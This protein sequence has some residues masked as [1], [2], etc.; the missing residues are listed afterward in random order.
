M[1]TLEKT[2]F[3]SSEAGDGLTPVLSFIGRVMACKTIEQVWPI[4][5]AKMAEYGFDRILYASNRFRT[6]GEFGDPSDAIVLT[7]HDKAYVDVFFGQSLFIHAPMAVWAAQNSGVCSWKWAA[8]RRA[9]GETSERENA[10][11]DLNEKFDVVAG[12]SI[13]FDHDSDR[14]KSAIGLCAR[15]GLTQDD[16]EAIWARHGAE[17][18]ELNNVVNLKI[19]TLPYERQGKPLTS[20]QREV[21][22]WVADGKTI[23]DVATIM[24]LNAAT[25]EKHL[26]LAR[27]VLNA[28]TTAQAVMKASVQ[29]QFFVF[30]A[31]KGGRG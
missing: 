5:T 26:R 29:N 28:D 25:V 3:D 14:L 30:S 6:H 22:Q 23:Q 13:S 11:M 21:L 9:R 10:V 8:D 27:E 16:V 2:P 12:Y 17:I 7:N 4:H 31:L 1:T 24:D 19:S 15:R 20:R 18:T